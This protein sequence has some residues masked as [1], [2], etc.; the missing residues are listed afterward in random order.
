MTLS[1]FVAKHFNMYVY[2]DNLKEL[3]NMVFTAS[4]KSG[5]FPAYYEDV[6]E[7]DFLCRKFVYHEGSLRAPLSMDSIIGMLFWI[8]K[9]K[10]GRTPK[11]QLADNVKTAIR[12]YFHHGKEVFTEHYNVLQEWCFKCNVDFPVGM[13]YQSLLEDWTYNK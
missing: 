3:F 9:P 8:R 2:R 1:R 12:E 4:N 11:A 10:D 6:S 7:V 5:V 13:T